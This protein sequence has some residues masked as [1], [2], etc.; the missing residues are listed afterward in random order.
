MKAGDEAARAAGGHPARRSD[1]EAAAIEAGDKAACESSR[2]ARQP[3]MGARRAWL[4]G[5]VMEAE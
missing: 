4:K 1:W 2:V 3:A 5:N